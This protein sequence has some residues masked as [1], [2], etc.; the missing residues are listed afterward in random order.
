MKQQHFG[1]YPANWKQIAK[2]TKDAANWCCVRCGHPH[3]PAAGY[4]LTVH[5]LDCNKSNC[6][7]W[8]IP[9]LCQRC[10]LYIQSKVIMH[11]PWL[12]P[13]SDWFKPYVAGYYASVGELPTDKAYVMTNVERLIAFGQG[14]L[15]VM[16]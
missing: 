11:R 7:W 14:L 13:H 1:E 9:P 10:H 3:E 5:H 2:E 6:A 15:E 4:C 16:P 12:L 8:N